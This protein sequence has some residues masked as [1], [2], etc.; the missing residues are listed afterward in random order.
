MADADTYTC[1]AGT[2]QYIV[3]LTVGGTVFD[4]LFSIFSSVGIIILAGLMYCL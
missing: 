3:N 4:Y 1:T 2:Y